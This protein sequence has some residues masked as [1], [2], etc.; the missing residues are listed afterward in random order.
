MLTTSLPQLLSRLN[1][2]EFDRK[3]TGILA[4]SVS[5]VCLAAYSYRCYRR[6]VKKRSRL[7]PPTTLPQDAFDAVIVG[8]GP[9]GSTAAWFMSRGGGKVAL[10]D[11]EKFPRDKYCGD[12]VCTPAIHILEEMGVMTELKEKNEVHFANAGGFVSPHGYCYIGATEK[13]L[14]E[15]AACAVKRIHLDTRLAKHA[16]KAGTVLRESFEVVNAEFDKS[17]CLWNVTSSQVSS[18]EGFVR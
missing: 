15:A 9:A 17:S 3:T 5:V 12:A 16:E 11:K 7:L 1:D 8:A 6:A 18:S 13:R 14:G 2:V 10:L 4:G